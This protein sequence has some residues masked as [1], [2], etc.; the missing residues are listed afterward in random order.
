I[1][2]HAGVKPICPEGERFCGVKVWEKEIEDY[3]RVL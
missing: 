2:K 3:R 1:R